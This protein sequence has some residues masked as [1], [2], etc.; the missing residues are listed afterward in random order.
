MDSEKLSEMKTICLKADKL[1]DGIYYFKEIISSIFGVQVK[2][3]SKN[4]TVKFISVPSELENKLVI[5]LKEYY[6][7]KL[8]NLEKEY[9]NL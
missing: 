4:D 9:K 8:K 5:L 1:I 6:S 7:E 2:L 3:K